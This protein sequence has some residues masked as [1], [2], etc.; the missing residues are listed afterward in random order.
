[1]RLTAA[2]LVTCAAAVL[3]RVTAAQHQH[4]HRDQHQHEPNNKNAEVDKRQEHPAAAPGSQ[5]VKA[6]AT[7]KYKGGH[8]EHD[9][10]PAR[11]P[12]AGATLRSHKATA[13]PT[14][15]GYPHKAVAYAAPVKP[16]SQQQAVANDDHD[17][18]D[19]KMQACYDKI[20]RPVALKFGVNGRGKVCKAYRKAERKCDVSIK[21]C[22]DNDDF[23]Y[24]LNGKAI[25]C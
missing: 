17:D 10:T 20:I 22:D 15:A 18:C 13:A 14:A 9:D 25:N 23:V 16:K 21:G 24:K 11:K 19:D 7:V 5:Q 12:A 3:M 8:D 6:V 4:Q 1:M 2:L